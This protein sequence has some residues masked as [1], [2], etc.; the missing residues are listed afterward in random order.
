MIYLIIAAVILIL[1]IYFKSPMKVITTNYYIKGYRHLKQKELFEYTTTP[2]GIPKIIIKTSWH[3]RHSMPIQMIDALETT[4]RLNPDYELY[5]FDDD[6]V[7]EFM[8][9]YS[10]N[11][12]ELYNKLVPGAFKADFFRVCFLYKYGGC[13]SD[14]GHIPRVSFNEIIGDSNIVLV[15]D[16]YNQVI[17]GID[18]RRFEYHGI[19]NALMCSTKKHPFFKAIIDKTIEN[20]QNEYYGENS[21]DVTGPTMIGKVFNCYF[22]N[23]CDNKNSDLLVYGTRDYLCDKCKVRI[24]KMSFAFDITNYFIT[25]SNNN[26][27]IQAKFNDYYNVMYTSKKT[28]RYT[29]LWNE[30]KVFLQKGFY[31]KNKYK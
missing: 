9:E 4:K 17:L 19:H 7:I 22:T 27:Y 25:D 3:K 26:V 30:K 16:Q 23:L 8:R 21:L 2:G 14:I 29:Q 15:K 28:P 18:V 1:F 6:E 20:I 31:L 11:A 5:Y 24:L 13:Y 12:L 10:D